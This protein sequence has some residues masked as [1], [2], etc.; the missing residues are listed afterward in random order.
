MANMEKLAAEELPL[1]GAGPKLRRAREACGLDLSQVAAETK[2]P[3]RHLEVIERGAFGELPARTY[4][5]GFTRTYARM[6]GLDDVEIAGEVRAELGDLAAAQPERATG[7]EPGDPAKTPSATLAWTAAVAAVILMGGAAMFYTT[8]Y[9]AGADPAPLIVEATPQPG[10]AQAT[11]PEVRDSGMGQETATA[12]APGKVALTALEDGIWV[13]IYDATG[14]RLIE[15]Q[16]M[17][18]E[19]FEIPTDAQE[20]RINTG[21]PDALA[22]TI[23][24]KPVPK[25]A[26]EPRTVGDMQVSARALLARTETAPPSALN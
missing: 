4:A 13:R 12:S 16:M 5:I 22:I 26:D 7:F 21:R 15:R 1:E 6:L 11:A 9:G 8:Y 25:L 2:I 19:Q 14:A 18:G 10:G 24:G 20:P 23:D 3:I 17:I